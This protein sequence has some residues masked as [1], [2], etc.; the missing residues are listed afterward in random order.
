MTA[1]VASLD[2]LR[3]A[4]AFIVVIPYYAMTMPGEHA[5]AEIISI[6]G[7]ENFF[8]LSGYV[9]AP[10]IIMV[11]VEPRR[12]LN[13]GIFLARRWLRTILP[14]LVALLIAAASFFWTPSVSPI[15]SRR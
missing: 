10:Q 2:L 8:V 12:M 3:G 15:P 4:A 9:L 11:A 5:L 1:R 6:L 14:Y 7:L 13:L